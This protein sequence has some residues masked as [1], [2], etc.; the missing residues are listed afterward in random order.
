MK[1]L[2]KIP[3]FKSE[4]ERAEFWLKHDSTEYMDWTQAKKVTFPKLK[5][6]YKSISLRLPVHMLEEIKIL[7]NK[8]DVPYQSLMKVF[9]AEKVREELAI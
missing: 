1:K 3:K 8:K 6:T 2:K 4:K 7:A 5:P 9:L